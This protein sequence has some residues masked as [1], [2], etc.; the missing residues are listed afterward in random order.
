MNS[1]DS[2]PTLPGQNAG[3][4]LVIEDEP[5]LR[6][7]LDRQLT[8]QHFNPICVS[9]GKAALEWLERQHADL[10]ILDMM[11]PIMD[12]LEVCKRIR[13]RFSA[14]KLPILMLSAMGDDAAYRVRGF[15]AGAN[16]FLAKPYVIDELV[17]R[18]KA[19]LN[20]K[21]EAEANEDFLA[22]YTPRAAYQQSEPDTKLSEQRYRGNATIMFADLRG[23]T[24]LSAHAEVTDV[25]QLLQDFYEAMMTV[26]EN[27][28]GVVID[29]K[30]DELLAIFNLPYPVP[31][32]SYLAVEAGC[33]MQRQF[34]VMQ[35][36]WQ[37][38]GLNV[39]LGIGIHQG[40]S[41]LGSIGGKRLMRY[42]VIGSAVN[43][44]HR[45]MTLAFDGEVIISRVV[46]DESTK[47]KAPRDDVQPFEAVLKGIEQLQTVY[48]IHPHSADTAS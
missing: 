22:R 17:G 31:L 1:S 19:L 18:I 36:R 37:S 41:L 39:G 20:V 25:L 21:A 13:Q 14:K 7:L 10:V 47:G 40:D 28:G 42:T 44:A 45:L 26:V 34:R 29:I 12:G 9:D 15:E 2:S 11:L 35:R 24:S 32:P 43:I 46:Y 33:E 6:N 5:S 27:H 3:I 8:F 38:Q 4:I 48:R 23:F 30:G 16:D